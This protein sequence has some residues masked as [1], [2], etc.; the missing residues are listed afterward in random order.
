MG[1]ARVCAFYSLLHCQMKQGC[2]KVN[3]L[4]DNNLMADLPSSAF[5]RS[6]EVPVIYVVGFVLVGLGHML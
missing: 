1:G 4:Q 2:L 6:N 5:S 3:F